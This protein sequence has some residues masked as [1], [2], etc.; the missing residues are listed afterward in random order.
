M[1]TI[2][3]V[4]SRDYP[5]LSQVDATMQDIASVYR[6]VRII[7]GGARGVDSRA[8]V[9]AKA[10]GLLFEE[11][12]AEWHPFGDADYDPS[13]GY[14]RNKRLV[15]MADQ[16]DAFWDGESKGTKHTIDLALKLRK[17]LVVHFP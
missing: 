6:N 2:A 15:E 5:A 11:F 14:K 7:S 17:T 16:V 10:L 8:R 13:A 9:A 12:P 3:V 1:I 4:G